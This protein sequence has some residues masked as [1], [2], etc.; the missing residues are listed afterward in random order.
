MFLRPKILEKCEEKFTDEME[1]TALLKKI[2]D[3]Y[4]MLKNLHDP[5]YRSYL[6]YSKDRVIKL[7]SDESSD[8]DP[9]QKAASDES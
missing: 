9:S 6:K 8:S 7:D 3:S 4:D 1:V 2:R 5:K